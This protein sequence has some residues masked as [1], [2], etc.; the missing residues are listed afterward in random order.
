VG[1]CMI[2]CAGCSKIGP[3]RPWPDATSKYGA[4]SVR[5]AFQPSDFEPASHLLSQAQHGFYLTNKAYGQK[6]G[7]HH[8][9]PIPLAVFFCLQLEVSPQAT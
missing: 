2:D 4:R 5:Q 8:H 6:I 1:A 9:F 3:P 7:L